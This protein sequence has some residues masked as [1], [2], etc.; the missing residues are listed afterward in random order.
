MQIEADPFDFNIS[1]Y[2]SYFDERRPFFTEGKEVFMPS[3]RQTNTGFYRPM[4]LFYS[5]R[6]G[7]LL[8]DGKRVPLI[9][10]TKAFTQFS[11]NIRSNFGHMSR[12]TDQD[13]YGWDKLFHQAGRNVFKE[14]S[15]VAAQHIKNHLSDIGKTPEEVKRFFLHQANINMNNKVI[16]KLLE[17]DPKEGEVP[18]ILDT[19]AN[20]ASAGSIIAFHFHSEDLAKGDLCVICSFG[21]GYS[22]G[23][24]I[25]RKR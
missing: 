2:E 25:L 24:L 8:P 14:V 19:Y 7:K 23:S 21:A 6:I 3:G 13:P 1:R 12:A 5:R 4:E 15:P 9:L 22:V 17:R 20:T 11:S 16:Q 18:I 10:G